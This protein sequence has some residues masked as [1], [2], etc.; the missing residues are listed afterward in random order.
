MTDLDQLVNAAEQR[1]VWRA[2]DRLMLVLWPSLLHGRTDASFVCLW[3]SADRPGVVCCGTTGRRGLYGWEA[4]GETVPVLDYGAQLE[5]G[6]AGAYGL[7]LAAEL[8]CLAAREARTVLSDLLD[9][10]GPARVM[11]LQAGSAWVPEIGRV[12]LAHLHALRLDADGDIPA[13]WTRDHDHHDRTNQETD[14]G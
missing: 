3:W 13:R 2:G 4:T 7:V 8:I 10:A 11:R 5:P 12:P 9:D 6:D 1:T 14:H